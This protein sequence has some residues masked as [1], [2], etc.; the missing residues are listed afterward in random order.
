MADAANHL[1]RAKDY[2]GRGEEFYRK[3]AEEIIA[4]QGSDPSL[5][6]GRIAKTI[7]KGETWVGDLVRWHTN[8]RGR[9]TPFGGEAH[10]ERSDKSKAKRILRDAP[11]Q[12]IAEQILSDPQVRDNVSRALDHHYEERA[13]ASTK[14]S[15]EREVERKGGEQAHAEYEDRQRVA[16][17]VSVVR[18]A[19][20]ALRFAA[21]QA[22]ALKLDQDESG[23]SEEL[24]TSLEEIIG[25]A[26]MLREFL[27][28][29]EITDEDIALLIGGGQ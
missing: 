12:Q 13:A 20:S 16:E 10:N 9:E 8:P 15:H 21:G 17:L 19:A 6:Y 27:G 24:R 1:A 23:G 28:G 26:S 29:R 11:P 14:R 18:G 2:I 25:F 22:K 4:A 7:G 3:A 5:G